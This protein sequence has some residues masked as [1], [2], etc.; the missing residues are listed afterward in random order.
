MG[1]EHQ[2]PGRLRGP[3]GVPRAVGGEVEEGAVAK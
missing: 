1:N 3:A 2:V